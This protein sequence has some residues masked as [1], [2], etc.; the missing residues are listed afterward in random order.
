MSSTTF[1]PL[2]SRFLLASATDEG[3]AQ[4]AGYVDTFIESTDWHPDRIGLFG[5]AL[6][7]SK[8]G[9]LKRLVMKQIAKRIIT[10]APTPTE[11]ADIE[12]TDW[13]EI[14]NFAADFATFVEGRL[15]ALPPATELHDHDP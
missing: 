10:D 3:R 7:Y 1:K 9:F 14:E 15:G 11:S 2:F 8:Y 12:F 6:R 4:A 5:G 13:K